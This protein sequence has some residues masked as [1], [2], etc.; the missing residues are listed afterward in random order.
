MTETSYYPPKGTPRPHDGSGT[1]GPVL[2]A[3]AEP[4]AQRRVTVL[5]RLIL[6]I[7]HY[8]ALC[9]LGFAATVVAFIGWLAALVTGRLPG[10]AVTYLSGYLRWY[11][12]VGAYLLLLT[13]EYPPFAFH[14]VTYPV[15]L[16][17]EPGKL[18]RLTVLF[19]VVLAIPAGIVSMLL[20]SGFTTIV[21]VIA[22]L[23]AL[24]A[25]RLPESLHQ[26]L[27][28]VLRYIVRY[29]GY[30]YLLTDSYPAGLFGDEPGVQPEPV[31]PPAEPGYGRPE[32]Y[33]GDNVPGAEH[34]PSGYGTSGYGAPGYG[35]PGYGPTPG[36]GAPAGF[37]TP[38][39][40]TTGFQTTGFD[41]PGYSAPWLPSRPVPDPYAGPAPNWRLVLS[42]GAKR[43][44]G[45]ILALG[46]LTAAGEG[47]WAGVTIN[48]IRQRDREISQLNK[49]VAQ[50]NAQVA[51]HNSAVASE[52]QAATKV[53]NAAQA[54]SSAHDTLVN[55]L[56]SPSTDSTNC[57]TV[58]CFNV[59][60][61]PVANAFAAFG[62]TL[63][64]TPVPPGQE[65]I[66][67]RLITDT[68][69]NEQ[70]WM[71]IVQDTSFTGIEDSAT[72]A[73]KVG[74]DWDND[75]ASLNTSLGNAATT[76]SDQASTLDNQ[77]DT[78]NRQGASLSRQ[79]ASLNVTIGLRGVNTAL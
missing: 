76:L 13:D 27:A 4:A 63:R 71:Q 39:F 15:R 29:Y 52:E 24:V 66:E 54:V 75:Y 8:V 56:N 6:A 42:P 62:R 23:T 38:G 51:V 74:T 36:Y 79:A 22:W 78:L 28:A 53:N 64:A 20:T 7:P 31:N 40:Q 16:T 30:V 73:E 3:V 18:N 46:L 35:A 48:S 47:A 44:V 37:Q 60:A 21:T 72:A 59:T 11:S 5:F 25:G 58:N 14:G 9:A 26:A 77:A 1:P 19:R 32:P 61:L 12:R 68:T 67:K 43:L 57:A 55:V 34:G 17:V 2:I 49:A 33:P 69:G 10:F 50:F 70:D 45:L 65:A 41:A